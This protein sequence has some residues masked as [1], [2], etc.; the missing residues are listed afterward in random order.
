[1]K[2]EDGK[3][4]LD[5][6]GDGSLTTGLRSVDYPYT[7]QFDLKVDKKGDAQLF[8]GRDGRLSI[9]SDGKLKIN[10]SYFEQKFDYT[11]PENKSV[12]VT[13]VGTQQVTKLYINGEFKQALTRTTNSETDY[14]HLL[15]T[16]VFPLTTIGNGFDGKIA[17]LKVYDKA[18]SPK[19]IKLA[20]E[21]KAVTEVNVAQDKAAAGT[22]QHKGDNN[23]DNANKKL[24]VGWKAIDGDGNTADG[25]HGTDVSEKDSFFEGLYADSSFAVDMLQTHQIDHLVLQW[26]K[27]PATFKLQV[28]SDGKVWKDI[29][30]KASIKGE[31]VNTIKFEQ[32]L[33]TRYIKMQGVDG[34]FQL[35]EFEAYETVNKDH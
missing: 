13:I 18:L 26:D 11:I 23:Y 24:R 21:G 31:S 34:T 8:D 7:V 20:A 10:R 28:S 17:D 2:E 9:G 1:M 12:N 5:L 3:N 22:A 30:G 27:A 16:F 32:P 35:R 29:E 19:T 4:W 25:K 6:N 33:E 15:S 14:N